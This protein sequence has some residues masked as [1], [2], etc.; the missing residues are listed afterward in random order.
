MTHDQYEQGS[1]LDLDLGDAGDPY[2]SGHR[3]RSSRATESLCMTRPSRFCVSFPP[4]LQAEG[5]IPPL[6]PLRA[7]S[8]AELGARLKARPGQ[9]PDVPF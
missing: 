4:F 6:A 1:T 8:G 2:G 3:V 9:A 5:L 7:G